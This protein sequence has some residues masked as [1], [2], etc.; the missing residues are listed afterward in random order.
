[1]Q[2]P[3]R[4]GAG[5]IRSEW[6][7]P[8]RPRRRTPEDTSVPFCTSASG[9][10]PAARPRSGA[11]HLADDYAELKR[12]I[13][14]RGLLER[15]PHLYLGHVVTLS[16]LSAVVLVGLVLTRGSWWVLAWAAPAAFLFGQLGFLAHD[17]AHNQILRSSRRNYV[18]GLLLFNL[19]LGGSRGW[20]ADKHNIHH[21]YPN[22]LGT[23][24]DIDGGVIAVSRE[25]A[26]QAR[27]WTR[28]FMRH[29]AGAI[30]P[31]MS[32][33]VLQI[34]L[35][36]IAFLSR[37]AV[38]NAGME[39]ALLLAHYTV[40]LGGLILLLGVRRGLLFALVNQMLLG[41]Y[42]GGAFLPNHTGMTALQPDEQMDFLR[43]QV[44]TA[45]NIRTSRVADYLLGAL[46][47]QIEHHLFPAMPRYRLRQAAP[48]VRQFCR[49]RGVSYR[50]TGMLEAYVEVYRHLD[51]VA[52]PLRRCERRRPA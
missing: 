2:E 48:V 37:R 32:L 19:F 10:A 6:D 7:V 16:L 3:S 11:H 18:L 5:S 26:A 15:T 28:L 12:L 24:P 9:D 29:Q 47:C 45:R 22:R 4:A 8:P 23:D 41:V 52:Q 20:W 44:L 27:G 49:E 42:L 14:G 1:M 38:R 43:R 39:A 30:W 25:Q 35:Q 33:G 50:E 34:H 36:S 21:A 40:Y 13:A 31:L 51:A 46:S 17:A